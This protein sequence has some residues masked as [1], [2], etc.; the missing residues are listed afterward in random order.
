[1]QVFY[2]KT[3]SLKS[4]PTN[5]FSKKQYLIFSKTYGT[6]GHTHFWG[7]ICNVIKA[8]ANKRRK[9]VNT[10]LKIHIHINDMNIYHIKI[11][12]VLF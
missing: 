4:Q 10:G 12:M 6:E 9:Y 3:V 11:I 2:A 7:H 1:M 8:S 5:K